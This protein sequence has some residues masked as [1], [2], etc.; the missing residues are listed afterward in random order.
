LEDELAQGGYP[1]GLGWDAEPADEIQR[2]ARV[3]GLAGPG[4]GKPSRRYVKAV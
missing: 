3:G 1:D 2:V 4:A